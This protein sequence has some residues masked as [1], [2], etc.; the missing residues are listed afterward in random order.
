VHAVQH[1]LLLLRAEVAGE[2]RQVHLIFLA[3]VQAQHRLKLEDAPRQAVPHLGPGR[4]LDGGQFLCRLDDGRYVLGDHLMVEAHRRGGV[5][6]RLD[7]GLDGGVQEPLF[8]H[9][10]RQ[11]LMPE[12]VDEG[13]RVGLGAAFAEQPC[14]LAEASEDL[15][16][17]TLDGLDGVA[18]GRNGT[19]SPNG[20][21]AVT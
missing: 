11:E 13:G 2:E 6:V 14:L 17:M 19:F 20:R 7:Q 15:G 3:Q 10:V 4:R 8:A 18:H 1:P 16:V 21:S 5:A 9:G 12:Q